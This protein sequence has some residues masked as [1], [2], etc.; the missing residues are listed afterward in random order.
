MAA[1]QREVIIQWMSMSISS[2]FPSKGQQARTPRSS[3][4]NDQQGLLPFILNIPAL[5]T[6]LGWAYVQ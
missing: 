1:L 5:S 4:Q 3:I 2:D 6:K